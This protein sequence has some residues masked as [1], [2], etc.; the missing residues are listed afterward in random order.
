[1]EL[2]GK[3]EKHESTLVAYGDVNGDTAMSKTVGITAAIGAELVMQSRVSAR[4]V[5]MVRSTFFFLLF[6]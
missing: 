3:L 2:G 4:G 1:M 5:L 6:I